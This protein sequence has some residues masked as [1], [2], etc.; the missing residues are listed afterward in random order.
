MSNDV[1]IWHTCLKC[2]ERNPS[3]IEI[4]MIG[5]HVCCSKCGSV[6]SGRF[7]NE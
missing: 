1:F 7:A 4:D 5:I 3:S 6:F 2:G